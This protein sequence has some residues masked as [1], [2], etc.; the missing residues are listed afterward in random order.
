VMGSCVEAIS[1]AE[2]RRTHRSAPAP[3]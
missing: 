1:W 2:S 3:R